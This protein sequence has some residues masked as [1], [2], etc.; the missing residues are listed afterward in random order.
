MQ[1]LS[2]FNSHN[3][4]IQ[5]FLVTGGSTDWLGTLD[6]TEVYDPSVGSW[7]MTRAKL[8]APMQGLRATNIDGRILLFGKDID[9]YK[10]NCWGLNKVVSLLIETLKLGHKKQYESWSQS[11]ASMRLLTTDQLLFHMTYPFDSICRG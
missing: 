1:K 6:S 5:V 9:S 2:V 7:M 4:H 10:Y 3:F 8:P 11:K